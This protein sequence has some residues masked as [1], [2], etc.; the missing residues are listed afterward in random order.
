M[1]R[2]VGSGSHE[3]G[4]K[5]DDN[6]HAASR[7]SH[8]AV[9][10][11][12]S[13]VSERKISWLWRNRLPLGK[14]TM[15]AGDP[16]LGKSYLTTYMAA[17]VTRADAMPD[18]SPSGLRQPADV[19]FLSAEDDPHDTILP[20]CKAAGADLRRIHLFEAVREHRR[21]GQSQDAMVQLDRH[22][23]SLM[24][25]LKKLE[26]P[27]L[28]VVD[29]IT[30]YLGEAD[31]NSNCAV[32]GVLR[33]LCEI[34]HATGVCVL[35]VTHLNKGGPDKSSRSMYRI[36]GS[37]AFSAAARVVYLMRAMPDEPNRRI[38]ACIKSNLA[39]DRGVMTFD[40][41]ENGLEWK[42]CNAGIDINA[43]DA[44]D[45]EAIG[46]GE[47]AEE[48][49]LASLADGP[50]DSAALLQTAEQ[51]GIALNTLRRAKRR[52]AVKA[53]RVGEKWMWSRGDG[54]GAGSGE[55]GKGER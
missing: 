8:A 6:A 20:R 39:I 27:R 42:D 49:L 3:G 54:G 51:S 47:E 34:A 16:G 45:D 14:V 4:F 31:G 53:S 1:A 24:R 18:G 37:L 55:R 15:L 32:R 35:C 43:I 2:Q 12:L 7:S 33:H 10:R 26:R 19:V 50:V 21:D 48:F 22:A 40:V 29:P 46:A 36:M 23:D 9:T 28:L 38:L 44:G 52:L 25:F 5:H 30:A 11:R 13:D 17:R 41:G